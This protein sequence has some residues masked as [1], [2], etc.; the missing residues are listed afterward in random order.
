MTSDEPR[1]RV[2]VVDDSAF[3][4]RVVRRVLER[5]SD[6]EIVDIAR[7]GA[8][9]LEKI[10]L[11]RPDVV[12][13]DLVMP[14]VDGLGVLEAL[15]SEDAPRVVVVS[16][17]GAHSELGAAALAAGAIDLVEKPTTQA[18]D[19][20]YDMADELIDR[21]RVAA[22]AR[23]IPR[24]ASAPAPVPVVADPAELP[25]DL[26]LFG[27]S[28]GGPQALARVLP[29]FPADFPV[30]IL[31]VVHMPVGYTEA[32]A[33]RLDGLSAISVVEG[34]DGLVL[35]RGMAVLAPF[36]AHFGVERG[37]IG[38][39]ARLDYATRAAGE[40]HRPS[41]DEL[42]KSAAAVLGPRVLAVVLTG[43]GDD[44]LDGA[45]ALTRAGARIVAESE[46]SCVVYGMPRAVIEHGLAQ[47]VAGLDRIVEVVR[48]HVGA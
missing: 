26:V 36:G 42:F 48:R 18:T 44:G 10:A 11:L 4:R 30:P 19:R 45:R 21:V 8:E 39:R 35:A 31:V 12:T 34:H 29:Q 32:L 33:Q 15:P 38:L 5:A 27:T 25:V 40:L 7:D 46:T 23:P 6:I 47:D 22:R 43:M 2:L 13:L 20:L 17:A 41:V 1:I 14:G 24:S 28:T 16:S 37:E 3:A 9:A